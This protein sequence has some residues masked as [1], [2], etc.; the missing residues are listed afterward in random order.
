MDQNL[1]IVTDSYQSRPDSYQ[2]RPEYVYLALIKEIA[3]NLSAVVLC[4]H[5]LDF[6]L[7]SLMLYFEE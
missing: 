5:L 4:K 2:S 7:V 3:I 1:E 6:M